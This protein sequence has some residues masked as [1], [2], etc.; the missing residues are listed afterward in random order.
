VLPSIS[1]ALYSTFAYD[2]EKIF[3]KIS[4]KQN[5]PLASPLL[6]VIASRQTMTAGSELAVLIQH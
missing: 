5:V 4:P 6:P 3:Q 1:L 2:R